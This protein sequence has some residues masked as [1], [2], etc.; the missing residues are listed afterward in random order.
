MPNFKIS[1]FTSASQLRFHLH[2]MFLLELNLTYKPLYE[3]K[4]PSVKIISFLVVTQCQKT[5]VYFRDIASSVPQHHIG[6]NIA[7]KQVK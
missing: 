3:L 5:Q 4:A 1:F 7:I 2:K 6:A